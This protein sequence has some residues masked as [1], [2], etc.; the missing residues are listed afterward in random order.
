[1]DKPSTPLQG[2]QIRFIIACPRSGSTLLMRIFAESSVC[3]VTSR[4]VLMGNAGGIQ[5][6]TPDYSI[7]EDPS[8]SMVYTSAADAGKRFLINK[9]E[10][11]NDSNKGECLYEVCPTLAAYSM[12]RPIFLI[13]DP[14]RVFDSW[15]NVGWIDGNSLVYCYANLFRML[16][17]APAHAASCLLYEHLI[18]EPQREIKR[19]CARWGVPFTEAMLDSKQPFGSSFVFSSDRE[20]D[21]YT[22]K[23]PLGLFTTVEANSSI[24]SEVP[25]HGLLSN[26][27]KDFIEEKLGRLYIHCWGDDVL[28]LRTVILEKSW[29]GFDLDDTLHEFRHSSGIATKRTL[30]EISSRFGTLLPALDEQYSKVLKEK[31]AN[32]FSDGKTSHDYR[33]DRFASV[34]DHFSLQYDNHFMDELLEI[35]EKALVESLELKAGASDLIT[36]LR[37]MGKKIVIMTE[38]PQDAQERTVQ[39]LGIGK[40]IDFLATTN[41]F[42]VTKTNGLFPK[43]LEHL[44]IS[45]GD[46]A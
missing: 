12:V 39:A 29:I 21:I 33:K 19:I 22:E 6:F 3:A 46:I 10:L 25:Y 1:M 18:Q 24:Q 16:N 41:H 15:K 44:G 42:G 37:N 11:G 36:T 7:L 35:Y 40:K 8:H 5:D 27:E 34:M 17:R 13:R 43:V 28:R 20:K 32:A 4:L 38:G 2:P 45:P 23:K 30:G 31:T 14:I 26:Y 9:E